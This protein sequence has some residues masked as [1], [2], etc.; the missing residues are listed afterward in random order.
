MTASITRKA[1]RLR[2]QPTDAETKLWQHLRRR[3]LAGRN[4]RAD[5]G[6]G[7]LVGDTGLEPVTSRV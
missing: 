5:G 7:K 4:E 6:A 1:R 3:Q 2:G